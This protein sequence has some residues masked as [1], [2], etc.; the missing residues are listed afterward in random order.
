MTP[1]A[2][3]RTCFMSTDQGQEMAEYYVSLLPDSRIDKIWRPQGSDKTL[4]VEFT[5]AGAPYMTLNAGMEV[6]H[7]PAM[8]ISVLTEDQAETD[9]LWFRLLGDGGQESQCG[10]IA[11][12]YGVNWQ[13]VPKVLPDLLNAP[14]REGANRAFQ[15]VMG[16]RRIDIAA[17]ERAFAG[18]TA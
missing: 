14:D 9:A 17:M 16:M 4:V 10:W 3:L 11:D 2:K 13:I 7:S 8:S 6:A 18:V 5:L 12:R 15:A 1:M